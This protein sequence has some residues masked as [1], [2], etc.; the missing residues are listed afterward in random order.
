MPGLTW[1]A[2]RDA[3]VSTLTP[4]LRIFTNHCQ[5]LM[6]QLLKVCE[7]KPTATQKEE[8]AT[9]MGVTPKAITHRIAHYR[10]AGK[11]GQSAKAAAKE[12]T[13]SPVTGKTAGVKKGSSL[14]EKDEDDEEAGGQLTPPPSVRPERNGGLKRDYAALA[15]GDED[16]AEDEDDGMGQEVKLKVGEDTAEGVCQRAFEDAMAEMDAGD[17]L[18]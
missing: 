14:K 5:K 18:G 12:S 7:V 8:L 17:I 1:N 10:G 4:V 11:Y 13:A 3:K 6:A 9:F 16:E 2:E 15:G